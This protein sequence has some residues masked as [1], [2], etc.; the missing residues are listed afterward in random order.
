[1]NFAQAVQ[2][3][4]DITKRPDK[5]VET[6]RAVNAALSFFIMKAEFPQDLLEATLIISPTDY[7]GQVSMAS[8][9]RFRRMKFV[10]ISG[11]RNYL[12]PISPEHLFTPGG[13]VQPNTY[14][15]TSTY[16]NYS[17]AKLAAALKV[18]Y[19]AYPPTLTA[20]DTHWFL[21][22]AFPCVIDRAAGVVFKHIGDD[23]SMNSH[24]QFAKEW[25]DVFVRDL[26]QP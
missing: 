13:L 18:G 15:L 3:V 5:Q 7:T 19:Y 25:Y 8:L 26:S 24:M 23:S 1:M 16:L 10:N 14:F 9:T 22:A 6:E 11:E 21:D 4:I 17:L 20:N 12:K 2:A